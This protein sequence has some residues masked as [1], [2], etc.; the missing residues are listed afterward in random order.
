[1][2]KPAEKNPQGVVPRRQGGVR[3]GIVGVAERIQD[4]S[5]DQKVRYRKVSLGNCEVFVDLGLEV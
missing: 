1:M 4:S 3:L 5:H 2:R